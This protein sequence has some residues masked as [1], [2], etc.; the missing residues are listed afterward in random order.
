VSLDPDAETPLYL[1]LAAIVRGRIEAGDIARRVPSIVSLQQEYG[2]A[3]GTV[4]R[5][6]A[7]LREEGL[8]RPVVG[9]GYFVVPAA[10]RSQRP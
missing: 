3:K 4:E 7:V 6:L 2:A 1:Q 8:V 10:E 9:R 5:A